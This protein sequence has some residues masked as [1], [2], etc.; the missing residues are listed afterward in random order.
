VGITNFPI[1]RIPVT[2]TWPEVDGGKYPAKAFLGE[3]IEFGAT[4]FRDG[5]DLICVELLL[6][7]PDVKTQRLSLKEGSPGMDQWVRE[8]Q[9]DQIGAW[10]YQVSA[11]DDVFGT[12]QHNTEIKLAAGIDQDLMMLEGARLL[13]QL[14]SGASAADKKRLALFSKNLLDNKTTAANRFAS[15]I[16][17]GLEA[18]ARANPLRG[19]ESITEPRWINCER[20]LAGSGAWY[21]FF[22][23][24]EGAKKNIDG[25][26]TSGTFKTALKSLARVADMGFEVLYLPPIHP[27]GTDHRKGPNNSLE[28][29]GDDP[30]SPWAIGN[31]AGGHDTIHPDLGTEKDFLAFVKAAAKLNIEIAMDLALQAAPN[32]PWVKTNPEFFTTR[33]DASIAYAENPPKKYQD[34]YPINFD[35]DPEGIYLEVMRLVEKWI[36]FGVRIFRV[37]NPHTKPVSFWQRLISDVNS[38]HPEVIFLAEAFTRPAMMHALGKAGFQQSY[39]YFTW[40]NHKDELVDYLNELSKK[41]ADFFRPNFW[42]NTPDILTQYL[43]FGGK[44]AFK[45]RA[46]IAAMAGPSWGMYAGFELYESVARAGAEENIDSEKYEYKSRDFAGA[47]LSEQSLAPRVALLNKIRQENP[48]LG[49]L[50]NLTTH[51]SD[52]Q[53]VLVFSKRLAAEHNQGKANTILVVV[54]TDPHSVRETMVHLNLAALGVTGDFKAVDLISG[55]E[56]TWSEHN[57]VRLDAFS[58]PAHILRIQH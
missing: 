16:E 43:Q 48:A 44:P 54:N 36:S 26:W 33:A 5:H 10:S 39:T 50:R 30:G 23:R 18:L 35:N 17:S 47:I 52:D 9:L 56:L 40:R 45:I 19:L 28:A 7:S 53:E 25:S 58:E 13:E 12:W 1:L 37:D 6:T 41:S 38:R 57:F 51:W 14:A 11:W 2:K 22:P 3:V 20:K 31:K 29:K 24:S 42:V 15:A 49:Q 55:T 4:A 21:E 46:T 32:H 34:I 8:V 27:I